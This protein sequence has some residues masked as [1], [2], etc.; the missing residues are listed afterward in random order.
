MTSYLP[1]ASVASTVAAPLPIDSD[2][3]GDQSPQT[4]TTMDNDLEKVVEEQKSVQFELASST[5]DAT[6]PGSDSNASC[7]GKASC[8]TN[9]FIIK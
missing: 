9:D 8:F 2:N 6:Q 1:F 4:V 3:M 7:A 5:S